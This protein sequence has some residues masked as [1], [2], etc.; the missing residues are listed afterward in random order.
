MRTK[1]QLLYYRSLLALLAF[2]GVLLEFIKYGSHMIMYYTILSNALVMGFIAYLVYLMVKKPQSSWTSPGI[3]RI[4]AGVTMAI[5]ITMVIYHVM[6]A[7]IADD[8]WRVENILCHYL[9]PALMLL[10]TLFFDKRGQYKS[11]DPLLWALMPL[12]YCGLALF[13]GLVTKVPIPDAKDS[14]FPYFFVNV[15]KYGWSYVGL[16]IVIICV[17]YILVG[18]LL[19]GIKNL[20]VKPRFQ[21]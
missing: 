15:T 17:A 14:P 5:L 9:V 2:L 1:D 3:L 13:N 18:Y 7:P 11:Y 6:L 10:D 21:K 8:F 19:Y 20:K 12:V 16:R 4:K